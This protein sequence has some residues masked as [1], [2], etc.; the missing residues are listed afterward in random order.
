MA[1][2]RWIQKAIKRPGRVKRLA[3]RE[4][5]LTKDGEVKMSWLI[6]KINEVKKRPPSKQ[7]RSLLQAL[8]LAKRL[9]VMRRGK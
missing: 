3:A 6:K 1:Q 8:Y 9:E 7:K 2:K 5:G 4:G